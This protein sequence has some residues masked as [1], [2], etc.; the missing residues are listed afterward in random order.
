[1]K[2]IKNR[3]RDITYFIIRSNLDLQVKIDYGF[4]QFS[5]HVTLILHFSKGVLALRIELLLLVAVNHPAL[6]LNVV[7][8]D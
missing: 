7:L 5:D 2:Y 6:V 8:V 4:M 1:M 3:R